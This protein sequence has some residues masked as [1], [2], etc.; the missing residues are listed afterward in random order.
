MTNHEAQKA[1]Y[2]SSWRIFFFNTLGWSGPRVSEWIQSTGKDSLLDDYDGWLYHDPPVVW[3]VEAMLSHV[4]PEQSSKAMI[5]VRNEI[6]A[7]FAGGNY[8]VSLNSDWPLYRKRINQALKRYGTQLPVA[9][10][11][12][13]IQEIFPDNAMRRG[14]GSLFA[15]NPNPSRETMQYQF[16]MKRLDYGVMPP[17]GLSTREFVGI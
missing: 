2:L 12:L 9:T 16:E 13:L 1:H 11:P 10:A 6:L 3:A 17:N 7:G 14:A 4:L 5:V 8:R 15:P